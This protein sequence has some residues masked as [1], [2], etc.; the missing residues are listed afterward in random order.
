M[1][2]SVRF[3]SRAKAATSQGP[4]EVPYPPGLHERM[5]HTH[6]QLTEAFTHARESHRNSALDDCAT[7]LRQFERNLRA[8]LDQEQAQFEEYLLQRL[9]GEHGRA[10]VVRQVRARLR[11]LAREAH[12]MLRPVSHGHVHANQNI[13]LNWNFDIMATI[14]AECVAT[15]EQDLMPQCLPSAADAAVADPKQGAANESGAW[16]KVAWR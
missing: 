6:A 3:W 10:L 13:D 8:Y 11:Q 2:D 15:T 16:P 14:L 7:H 5:R 12:E 4:A 1:F 9:S